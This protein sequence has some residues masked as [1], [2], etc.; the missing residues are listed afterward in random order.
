MHK[1]K[2]D[3]NA[4]CNYLPECTMNIAYVCRYIRAQKQ[5]EKT[6]TAIP[7]QLRKKDPEAWWVQQD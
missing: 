5:H 4:E 1:K 6:N 7:K 3:K 2:F